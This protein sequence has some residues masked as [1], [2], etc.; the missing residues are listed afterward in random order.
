MAYT[1][2][3]LHVKAHRTFRGRLPCDTCYHRKA[4]VVKS[5]VWGTINFML[6]SDFMGRGK[7]PLYCSSDH[8]FQDCRYMP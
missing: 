6:Y 3:I 5:L 1:W 7:T 2:T 4:A 8:S